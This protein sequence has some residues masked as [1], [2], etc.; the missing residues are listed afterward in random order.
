MH[1][2]ALGRG[3]EALIPGAT[4]AVG[5]AAP[6]RR[7]DGAPLEIPIDSIG[8]N[9]HQPRQRFDD[10]AIKELAASIKASGILQPVIV[11][12][13]PVDGYE[14]VAGERRLRAARVAG[15][16]KVPAILREVNDQEMLEMAL[17]ENIQRENLNPIEEA[18]AYQALISRAGLTHD[19]VSERVGK[20]R[21]TISNSLRLLTL[22]AEV[23]DMVSRETLSAGHARAL[24]ALPT[25]GEQL[26]SARY[27]QSKGFSVRRTEAY[28]RRKLRRQHT[29]PAKSASAGLAEWETRLQQKFATPVV[30]QK[31]RRG[32]RVEFEYFSDE[33]LERLL[34]MWGVM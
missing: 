17:V 13:D 12:R 14:L 33:D 5:A 21:T 18:K 8:P 2:K 26:V 10:E 30:I 19:E 15:L 24:I 6:E 25:P 23:Q 34:E 22:P 1:R 7:T 32:G 11:R 31:T 28:I 9:P 29:R 27:V 16:L 3:L 4:G 20:Q